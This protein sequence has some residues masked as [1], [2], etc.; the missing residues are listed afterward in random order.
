MWK[1]R[2]QGQVHVSKFHR[3]VFYEGL[4]SIPSAGIYDQRA[5]SC[6]RK[7]L[8]FNVHL[9]HVFPSDEDVFTPGNFFTRLS[10]PGSVIPAS[11]GRDEPE[12]ASSSDVFHLVT[13]EFSGDG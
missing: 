10:H 11:L 7:Q 2:E 1:R 3:F 8:E 4:L 5:M 12:R 9:S 13:L 6:S